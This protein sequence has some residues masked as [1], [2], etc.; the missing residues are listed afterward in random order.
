MMTM[1]QVNHEKA[2]L[3]QI[4]KRLINLEK[5][6]KIDKILTDGLF[7]VDVAK[8]EGSF[9]NMPIHLSLILND[10]EQSVL[11]KGIQVVLEFA[12][13]RIEKEIENV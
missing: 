2:K 13:Q 9:S 3:A 6:E 7:M 10:A 8:V 5:I 12:R 1:E 11:S 4:E